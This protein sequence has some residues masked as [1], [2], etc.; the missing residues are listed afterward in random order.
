M[1]TSFLYRVF[2][3]LLVANPLIASTKAPEE[4]SARQW[5]MEMSEAMRLLNYRG[6][7]AYLKNNQ[8]ETM[9]VTH[10]FQN[11][12]ER[13]HI[14]ALS[15]PMREV[16]RESNKV[17]CYFPD[18]QTQVI[19]HMP[20]K[21]SFFVNLPKDF[22]KYQSNYRFIL[23][24]IEHVTGRTARKVS[25]IP[26]DDFRYGQKIWIDT[27]SYLPLKYELFNQKGDVIEQMVF[28]SL[29]VTHSISLE[30]VKP[31]VDSSHFT[32]QTRNLH[33]TEKPVENSEWVF[34]KLPTGFKIISHVRQ[35]AAEGKSPV[36]HILLS[37]GLVSISAYIEKDTKVSVI[38]KVRAFG[39]VSS[40]MRTLNDFLLTVVGEVPEQT[41]RL[42]GES[43]HRKSRLD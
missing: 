16:I 31:I 30:T 24:G 5:L 34:S 9:R 37:D 26:S 1:K 10:A 21:H 20:E 25:I 35:I 22:G 28:T 2:F 32:K 13:E 3:L 39:A 6:N 38:S 40:Y 7:I 23:T 27:E 12:V 43:L 17:T 36:E 8:I 11:G 15:G 42:I 4:S 29:D 14:L 41:V 19:D 33:E 18:S